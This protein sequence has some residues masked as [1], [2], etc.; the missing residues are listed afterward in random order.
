MAFVSCVSCGTRISVGA[1]KSH[2]GSARCLQL[3][4]ERDMIEQNWHRLNSGHDIAAIKKAGVK[5]EFRPSHYNIWVPEWV[6]KAIQQFRS[7]KT[8]YHNGYA[9]LTLSEFLKRLDPSNE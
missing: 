4:N 1:L 9:D 6:G 2:D 7:G 8:L 5:F 3:T